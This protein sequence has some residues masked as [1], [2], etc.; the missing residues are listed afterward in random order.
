MKNTLRSSHYFG[1]RK[2]IGLGKDSILPFIFS[3]V[4][5]K[6]MNKK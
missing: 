2:Y 4:G 3:Y 6:K 5:N 1:E